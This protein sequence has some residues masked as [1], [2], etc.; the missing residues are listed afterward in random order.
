MR[1]GWDSS[2][3][4]F[5]SYFELLGSRQTVVVQSSGSRRAVVKQLSE[6]CRRVV[7]Q[8]SGCRQAVVGQSTPS[9][10][11]VGRLYPQYRDV[12]SNFKTVPPGLSR[13]LHTLQQ[14]GSSILLSQLGL[15][16][17]RSSPER[18][19]T[20]HKS[21][22]QLYFLFGIF[23]IPRRCKYANEAGGPPEAKGVT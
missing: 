16:G 19:V 3:T 4:S 18:V 13:D 12:P 20:I 23:I 8:S 7:R 9:N 14:K 5:C 2:Q 17:G 6:S 21:P 15:A 22:A 1:D 10:K 11:G